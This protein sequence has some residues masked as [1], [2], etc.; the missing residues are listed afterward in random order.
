[1]SR[2]L[3]TLGAIA[4]AAVAIA[5]LGSLGCAG[6][7]DRTRTALEALDRGAPREAV[8]ALDAELGV[9]RAEDLPQ[10]KGDNAL[11]LLDRATVQQG[12]D[13]FELSAR[14]FGAADKAIDLLDMSRTGADEL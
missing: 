6:H 7:E 11:L 1:M 4:A 9:G 10:L 12:L 8:A 3:G 13:R 5:S 2:Q 14:D